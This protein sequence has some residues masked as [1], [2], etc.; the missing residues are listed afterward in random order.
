MGVKK[1]PEKRK[2]VEVF[3]NFTLMKKRLKYLHKKTLGKHIIKVWKQ[4]SENYELVFSGFRDIF[5][6]KIF[7]LNLYSP[8]NQKSIIASSVWSESF[9]FKTT[10]TISSI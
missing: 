5:D 8:K 4:T 6:W 9:S 3:Q 2:K 1:I 7:L 10:I